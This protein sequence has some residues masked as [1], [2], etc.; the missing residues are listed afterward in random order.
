MSHRY[1]LTMRTS[2]SPHLY[3]DQI[4]EMMKD[5]DYLLPQMKKTLLLLK[6]FK[7]SFIQ[8]PLQMEVI[9]SPEFSCNLERS[10]SP[11]LLAFNKTLWSEKDLEKYKKQTTQYLKDVKELYTRMGYTIEEKTIDETLVKEFVDDVDKKINKFGG[12]LLDKV[13]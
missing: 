5:D 11:Q 13:K 7:R 9:I 12:H 1:I 3:L 2:S 4:K 8:L 10:L 6:K